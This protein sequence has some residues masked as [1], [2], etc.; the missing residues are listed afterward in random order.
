MLWDSILRNAVG[1]L[2]FAAITVGV[3]AVTEYTTRDAIVE[4]REA[5]RRRAL[6]EILPA[7]AF[8]NAILEDVIELDAAALGL[9]EAEPAYIARRD[10]IAVA[11]MVP[12]RIPDGYS[13]EIRLLLGVR[14][15][16]SVVGVRTL[17][18][19]ETPGLGDKIELRKSD[20]IK[21]FDDR[22]LRNPAADG[23]AVTKDGGAFDGFTGATITPRA[24]ITGVSR[25]L[26]WFEDEG[27][28]A[29]F[30]TT[31]EQG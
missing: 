31:E 26:H 1:L 25:A 19:R 28:R 3:I 15:D 24:V 14:P 7:E 23:W 4:Q 16:G 2:L 22:S 11:A 20:W 30:G 18:H 27:R 12:V 17:E 10:G 21:S 9:E 5:A 6:L 13:G 29:L 8:D